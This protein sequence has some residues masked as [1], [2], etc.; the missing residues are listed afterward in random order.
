MNICI[1]GNKTTTLALIEKIIE[2]GFSI[3][4]LV[5]LS[6]DAASK[7]DI[8]GYGGDLIDKAK[9]MGIKI[10]FPH[11]YSLV[12]DIDFFQ[13]QKFDIGISTGWQ[14]IIPEEILKTFKYGVYGWHGSGFKFP[15]GR[16]RSPLNWSIR[17]GLNKIYHNCFK[18]D[19]G[20]DSGEVF[21]TVA[22]SIEEQDYIEDVQRKA[23]NHIKDSV[24]KLLGQAKSG[25]ISLTKQIIHP[26]IT[27]PLLNSYS[28]S[29]FP[30]VMDAVEARMII[31]SCSHPFPGAYVE[32]LKYDLIIRIWKADIVRSIPNSIDLPLNHLILIDSKIYI[33]FKDGVL[34]SENFQI[35][36]NNEEKL[37]KDI[38]YECI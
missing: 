22:F 6:V 34:I 33:A 35:E 13:N 27:F 21:D 4:T 19:Q 30:L 15:N 11:S 2:S 7:I 28:G 36:S 12:K 8:S 17:L 32:L 5:A 38:F 18:Y 29:L 31:K 20:V 9:L 14:R 25:R 24:I 10:Y 16:G 23:L 37:I 3:N 1:F 26:H